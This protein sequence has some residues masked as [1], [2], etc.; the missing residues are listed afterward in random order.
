[1]GFR[2]FQL[3][4]LTQITWGAGLT[5]LEGQ[6][7]ALNEL[8]TVTIPDTVVSIGDYAFGGNPDL[9]EV[10]MLPETPPTMSWAAFGE[11]YTNV[12]V[13]VSRSSFAAYGN[14]WYGY[15]TNAYNTA[16]FDA[17]QAGT[18]PPAQAVLPGQSAVD[19]GPLT[20]PGWRFLGWFGLPVGGAL[21]D[22]AAALT[23]DTVVYAQWAQQ[24]TVTFDA[25]EL[26]APIDA[27]EVPDGERALAPPVPV[28]DGWH[29][30]GWF[31][32]PTAPSQPFDFDTP[33]TDDIT[34]HAGWTAVI[35]SFTVE[36]DRSAYRPGEAIT[37]RGD[38]LPEGTAV[39][40]E[41]RSTPVPLGTAIVDG[42]GSYE[43]TTTIPTDTTFGARQ[44]VAL[45]DDRGTTVS[46]TA[47]IMVVV[48]GTGPGD[49]DSTPIVDPGTTTPGASDPAGAGLGD[50]DR[51]VTAGA[52][53]LLPRTG[54]DLSAVPLAVAFTLLVMGLAVLRHRRA[55][56][57]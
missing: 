6:A 52:A 16:T 41:L 10:R 56:L 20:A 37:V 36:T 35:A 40:I 51:E 27:Q 46:A 12:T 2:A 3:N 29:F 38:G 44:I 50:R 1:M 47:D 24:H 23:D 43:L 26:G 48:P 53:H 57:G 30:D 54:T 31:T 7:F 19:P 14:P 45:V 11:D 18:A 8:T 33:I 5:A 28:A 34:V 17:G 55:L 13:W 9:T 49:D 15:P 42:S 32:D 39:E 4:E 22:F 21:F 25:G